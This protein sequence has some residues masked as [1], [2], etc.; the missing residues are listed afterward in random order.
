MLPGNGKKSEGYFPP[1]NRALASCPEDISHLLT[2]TADST[3]HLHQSK[4][5]R[6]TPLLQGEIQSRQR[7]R[8]GH[9]AIEKGS[10]DYICFDFFYLLLFI[11]WE[12]FYK[13]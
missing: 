2:L 9:M 12:S 3:M 1:K 8:N 13:T 11:N 7:S 6:E 5:N 4:I 10:L